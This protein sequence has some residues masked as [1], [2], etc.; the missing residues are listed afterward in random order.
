MVI[1]IING[2]VT[3]M[4]SGVPLPRLFVKAFDKERAFR[5][6]AGRGDHR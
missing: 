3:E 5:Q 6:S 1:F 2:S 4:E